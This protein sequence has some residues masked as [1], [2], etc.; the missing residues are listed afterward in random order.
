MLPSDFVC[1]HRF[2]VQPPSA[3]P[4]ATKIHR[5]GLLELEDTQKSQPP[6]T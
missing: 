6:V 1:V 3:A 5:S 2:N 4:T